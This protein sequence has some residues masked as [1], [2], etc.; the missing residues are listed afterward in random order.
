MYSS[1]QS[2]RSQKKESGQ[3][4]ISLKG[5]VRF[6]VNTNRADFEKGWIAEKKGNDSKRVWFSLIWCK[7]SNEAGTYFLS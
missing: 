2:K 6:R 1:D 7:S 5:K 3:D 4:N